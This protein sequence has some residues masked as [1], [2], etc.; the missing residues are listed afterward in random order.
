MRGNWL[1]QGRQETDVKM[2]IGDLVCVKDVCMYCNLADMQ[3]IAGGHICQV[4]GTE[5]CGYTTA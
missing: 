2:E 5:C 3:V 1:T 4:L